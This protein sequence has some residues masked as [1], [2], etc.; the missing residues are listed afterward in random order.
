[1]F[2]DIICEFDAG[3]AIITLSRPEARNAFTTHTQQEVIEAF[4][5]AEEDSSVR[6]VVLTG[7]GGS[8]CAGADIK[9]LGEPEFASPVGVERLLTLDWDYYQAIR[10]IGKPVIAR[11]DGH[12]VGGGCI[13]ALMCDIR[14]ASDDAKIGLPF[15]KIGLSGADGGVAYHLPRIIWLGRAMELLLTGELISGE[16]A[17]RIGL[18]N[19]SVPAAHLDAKV[20][21]VADLLMS[22]SP[23]ALRNTKTALQ[24][25]IDSNIR[26][27]FSFEHLTT[28]RGLM[29]Q[30]WRE[31][32]QAFKE[33]RSPGFQGR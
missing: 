18:V 10:N 5:L 15:V 1:M 26:E 27:E 12:A 21:E 9:E 4:H 20:A 6:V 29:S 28:V 17:R 11:I 8:F 30:D 33:R 3:V 32:T 25:S 7:A 16:R 19:F 24:R 22:R 14:I 2:D 13:T 31:G 23:L